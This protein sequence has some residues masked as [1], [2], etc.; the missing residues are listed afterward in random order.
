[1]SNGTNLVTFAVVT[2]YKPVASDIIDFQND[3]SLISA[4][5][6]LNYLTL[7]SAKSKFM[8]ISRLKRAENFPQFN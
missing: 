1:M 8:L 7:Y 6:N 2:L 5:T 3:V 4:R